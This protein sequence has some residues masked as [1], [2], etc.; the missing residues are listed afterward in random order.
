MAIYEPLATTP[1]AADNQLMHSSTLPELVHLDDPALDVMIDF[2]KIKP[3]TVGL[4]ES[5]DHALNEMKVSGTH[6]LLVTNNQSQI[7]GIISTE[8]ILGERPIKAMQ[9]RHI[10]RA[11]VLVR[12][13]MTPQ[14]KVATLEFE[15]LRHA[16]V[17]HI[18][19]TLK[20]LRQHYLLVIQPGSEHKQ[21]VRGIFSSS[22]IS[23]QLHMD[24]SNSLGEAHSLAELKKRTG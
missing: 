23:R 12:M 21:K 11:H 14:D 8:D 3:F 4:Q 15:S 24:I 18:I 17:A 1:L 16:K 7:L 5:I 6:V 22:E 20:A 13:V 19:H 2:K 10:T 9:E